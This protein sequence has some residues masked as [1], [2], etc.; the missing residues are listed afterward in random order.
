MD[1]ELVAILRLAFAEQQFPI[2]V[3]GPVGRGKSFA[4][5]LV[6]ARW[7]STVAYLPYSDFIGL[8]IRADKDGGVTR[9]LPNGGCLEMSQNEWWTW[10]KTVNLLILDDLGTGHSGEWR[11][12]IMSKLLDLRRGLP[13]L[14]TGN[15]TLDGIKEHFD[16]RIHDRILAGGLVKVQ[17]RNQR[18]EGIEGRMY[19]V[20][21]E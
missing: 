8:S 5:A 3:F 18:R 21:G 9:S 10:I 4:A 15:L 7:T 20:E 16:E 1:P 12:E 13:M 11:C 19:L 2:Y 6:Y 17:G 14:L